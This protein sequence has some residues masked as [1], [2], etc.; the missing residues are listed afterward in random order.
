MRIT[1]EA[2]IATEQ[3]ILEAAARLFRTA[4]W[5]ATTTREIASAAGIASGTLFNYF[6]CKEAIA[7]AL[8][9][10]ALE[11]A[12]EEFTGAAREE[13]SL[14][15]DLFAFIWTGLKRLRKCR[16]QPW[17]GRSNRMPSAKSS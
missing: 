9:S 13:T 7:A 17:A 2:K 6:A 8:I 16:A 4:G 14:E 10:G 3:R 5:E 15:E 11:G 1:Q 12:E